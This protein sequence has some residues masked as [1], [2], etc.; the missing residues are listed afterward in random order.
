MSSIPILPDGALPVVADPEGRDTAFW[1][2]T[3]RDELWIQRCQQCGGFQ[4]LP[5]WL[6]HRCHSF[7]LGFDRVEP[8]GTVYSWERVWHPSAPELAP[9]CPFVIVVVELDS[10]PGVRLVGNL[11]GPGDQPVVIGTP[12]HASFEHHDDYTLV[13]WSAQAA[14]GP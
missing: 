8:T 5:E 10:A 11:I 14:T 6:C 13:Q 3:R 4:W 9:A 2:G 7:D 12:V 1:Q